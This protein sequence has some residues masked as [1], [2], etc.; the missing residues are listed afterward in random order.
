MGNLAVGFSHSA[1]DFD[2]S[3]QDFD[4]AV[5]GSLGGTARCARCVGMILEPQGLEFLSHA[6]APRA[7]RTIRNEENEEDCNECVLHD[8]AQKKN[9]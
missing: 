5:E 1:L 8:S 3:I 4:E 9:Q 6:C 7:S 2:D